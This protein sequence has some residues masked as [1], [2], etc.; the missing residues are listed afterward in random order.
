MK[1]KSVYDYT[2]KQWNNWLIE[3]K[4]PVYRAKQIFDWLYIK[5]I[6]SFAE[7]TNLTK[8]LRKKLVKAYLT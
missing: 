4:E 3:N 8:D 1:K 6:N 7:M 5:R 2:L